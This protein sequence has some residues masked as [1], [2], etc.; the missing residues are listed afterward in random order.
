MDNLAIIDRFTETFSRYIDSGFGLLTGEIAFLTTILITIDLTLAGLRWA[1]GNDSD[2]FAALIRKILYVGVFALLLNNWSFLSEVI[3]KSF[4]GLG[5][6]ATGNSLTPDR[7]LQ[8][9]FI[10][11]TGFDAAWPLIRAM[12]S[13]PFAPSS[14]GMV[15]LLAVSWLFVVVAFFIL[16]VQLL[17]TVIEFKLT[18]LAGF[19]LVP[20]ALWNKSAFLAE[21]VLGNVISSGIKM[22][23]LAV[24]LAIG[25]TFFRDITAA[26][27]GRDPGLTEI[28]SLLLASLALFGLGIFGPSIAAGL[29]S[30]APQLGAG[31]ALGTGAA[32][33]GV[34][35][36]AAGGTLAALK[37]ASAVGSGATAA[38]RAGQAASGGNPIGG[39]GG[40]LHAGVG[41]IGKAAIA[42]FKNSAAG[43]REAALRGMGASSAGMSGS[44]GTGEMPAWAKQMQ[45]SQA[46][47]R[48]AKRTQATTQAIKAGDR[49]GA[50]VNPSLEEK[51]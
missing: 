43:G 36:A 46:R 24:I 20:F 4:A 21:R 34:T 23:V 9:G 12:G 29:V 25:S 11:A 38:F 17:V 44:T 18:S 16:S 49:S 6:Q 7:L 31:A 48:S 33:L 42:P 10:A 47:Q 30:G 8:P 39:I 3:F 41:S 1:G 27:Q 28:A 45:A 19:V 37:A 13:L 35:A 26:L 50:P 32:T 22:M 14:L 40:M 51:D 2:V 5:L 15:F